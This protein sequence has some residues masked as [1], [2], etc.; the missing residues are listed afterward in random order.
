MNTLNNQQINPGNRVDFSRIRRFAKGG[1]P[2][3]LNGDEL[4]YDWDNFKNEWNNRA[5]TGTATATSIPYNPTWAPNQQFKSVDEYEH[6]RKYTDFTNYVLKNSNNPEVL[7]YLKMLD[8]HARRSGATDGLLFTDANQTALRAG[9]DKEYNRLRNDDKYGWFHLTPEVDL[10]TNPGFQLT[11]DTLPKPDLSI[12]PKI[13]GKK[14]PNEGL[15]L[16]GNTPD[17]GLDLG[18]DIP[19]GYLPGYKR[20]FNDT[21][22]IGQTY[23]N[24][25]DTINQQ[26]KDLG[27]TKYALR[28]PVFN[29]VQSTSNFL[30]Q[31]GIKQGL[32]NSRY[33]F[34]QS[35]QTGDIAT[36]QANR[37]KFETGVANPAYQQMTGLGVQAAQTSKAQAQQAKSNWL[38]DSSNSAFINDQTRAAA[39]NADNTNKSKFTALRGDAKNQYIASMDASNKVFQAN[40]NLNQANY[41]QM[42]NN[43]MAEQEQQNILNKYDPKNLLTSTTGLNAD[44]QELNYNGVYDSLIYRLNE[45]GKSG[46]EDLELALKSKNDPDEILRLMRKYQNINGESDANLTSFIQNYDKAY[47]DNEEALTKDLT[48]L[49]NKLKYAN[50]MSSKHKLQ[51][52][53]VYDPQLQTNWTNIDFSQMPL[54]FKKGGTLS[55]ADRMLKYSEYLRKK[56]KDLHDRVHKNK[57]LQHKTL[58]HQLDSLD[59]ET[60]LLLRAIFK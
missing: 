36:A 47:A 13:P 1:V 7:N 49:Q 30:E 25:I 31:Q 60:L 24:T 54:S 16:G 50:L 12:D 26:E 33:N 23:L 32:A 21:S 2:K 3:H 44:G 37:L 34:E 51:Y 39:E 52:N 10:G 15:D 42:V 38:T 4:L 19:V 6:S 56:E 11:V 58:L 41:N 35:N 14:T 8:Q 46:A 59:R 9:W 48:S 27:N 53:N 17:E 29:H 40:E 5:N 43:Y 18:D 22:A 45:M 57:E 55:N 28:S 20:G